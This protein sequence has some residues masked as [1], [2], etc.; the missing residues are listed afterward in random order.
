MLV[1]RQ[2]RRFDRYWLAPLAIVLGIAAGLL[3]GRESILISTG[4]RLYDYANRLLHHEE[5]ISAE[6]VQVAKD[7]N[8]SPYLPCSPDDI[9]LLRRI[10]FQARFIK[11]AGRMVDGAFLCSATVGKL[12]A[13]ISMPVPDLVLPSGDHI[14]NSLPLMVPAGDRADV[15]V[16]G[17]ADMVIGP[18]IF[19]DYPQSPIHYAVGI[20]GP[21]PDEPSSEIL[22]AGVAHFGTLPKGI[23]KT[24]KT[25][26]DHGSLYRSSCSSQYPDCAVA[27][28]S[29]DEVWQQNQALLSGFVVS[30]GI[31][32]LSCAVGLLIVGRKRRSH[33]N[34]LRRAI[35]MDSL[36]VVYQPIVEMRSRRIVGAE[37]LARWTDEEGDSIRPET[38]IELAEAEGFVSEI[39]RFVLTRAITE[40]QSI[41]DI[42]PEFRLNINLAPSDLAD[43]RLLLLLD[44]CIDGQRVRPSNIAFELPERATSNRETAIGAIRRLRDRGH[45]TFIDDFGTGYSN[46][47]YLTELHVD[48]IKINRSFIATIGTEA[49]TASIVPQILGVAKAL[50]LKVV[51]QGIEREDQAI[52]FS[53][54]DRS[55][56]GQGWFFGL[57]VPARGLIYL[58]MEKSE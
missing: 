55:I 39:T 6:T 54:E 28:M 31:A 24:N 35:L 15:A 2:L 17:N 9:T 52:Y 4:A 44:E 56:L 36:S 41:F 21:S 7:A 30:G 23:L 3:V 11:D 8:A 18:D 1:F 38:I 32:G 22:R 51:V 49:V 25:V 27:Y 53:G 42:D 19:L 33:T 26:R 29:L 20:I 14:Y 10:T 57:P 5:A 13:P 48:G 45:A 12:P 16:S 37:A 34:Q 43:P 50:S 40:I 46:L 47:A 58:C